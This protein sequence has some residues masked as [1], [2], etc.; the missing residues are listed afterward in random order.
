[1]SR[2]LSPNSC[3]HYRSTELTPWN[4]HISSLP[5]ALQDLPISYSLTDHPNMV[6]ST[7]YEAHYVIFP[8]ILLL[9]LSY[10]QTFSSAPCSKTI[11]LQF[12]LKARNHQSTDTCLGQ[13]SAL[14]NL[15]LYLNQ[16]FFAHSLLIALMTEVVSTSE[17]SANFYQ[18][19]VQHPRRQLYHKFGL[20]Q[21]VIQRGDF[22]N[23]QNQ[24][25]GHGSVLV[26]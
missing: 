11:N 2:L 21:T 10:I 16:F 12:S 20:C 7:N 1:V 9:P 19:T 15:L 26:Q 23:T 18:T 5:C 24:S 22:K 13:A 17:M 14:S 6:T 25:W 4:M 8:S 3:S